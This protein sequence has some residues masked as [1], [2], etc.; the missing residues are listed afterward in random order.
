MF[1]LQNFPT[2]L[3]VNFHANLKFLDKEN[4]DIKIITQIKYPI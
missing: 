4:I 3:K 1:I 2:N